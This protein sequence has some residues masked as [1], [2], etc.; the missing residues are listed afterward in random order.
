[1]YSVYRDRV[2]ISGQAQM[3]G[4]FVFWLE[5]AGETA[6]VRGSS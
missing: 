4:L 1:M 6:I 3:K 5:D 2:R